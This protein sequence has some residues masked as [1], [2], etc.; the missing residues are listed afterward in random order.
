MTKRVDSL[1]ADN[2]ELIAASTY[3]EKEMIE[4]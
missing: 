1:L 2:A 4:M 3:R